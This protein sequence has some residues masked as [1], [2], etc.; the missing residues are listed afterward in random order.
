MQELRYSKLPAAP[1]PPAL[2]QPTSML[3][4]MARLDSDGDACTGEAAAMGVAPLCP[5]LVPSPPP[6]AP[7]EDAVS[8]SA[9]PFDGLDLARA[10]RKQRATK[11]PADGLERLTRRTRQEFRR[12]AKRQ[13]PLPQPTLVTKFDKGTIHLGECQ[14]RGRV[15]AR[16][17]G[18]HAVAAALAAHLL[19][20]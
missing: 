8:I 5:M 3:S 6:S 19:V 13:Q 16:Q 12:I 4:P 20:T 2:P 9:R 10:P 1:A 15:R 7:G 14:V 11:P 18:A 17:H